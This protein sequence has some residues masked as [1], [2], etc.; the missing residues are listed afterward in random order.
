ML[1]I[2]G[3]VISVSGVSL[4]PLRF[5][6]LVRRHPRSIDQT[7]SLERQGRR[8][9]GG[10]VDEELIVFVR[11]VSEWGGYPKT[12]QR[13]FECND[14]SEVR[15]RFEN[16]I[17]A[18]TVDDPHIT[19]ALR[20]LRRIRGLGISFSSKHLRLLRPDVCP[21][22][23]SILSER[24]GYPLNVSGY[25]RFSDACRSVGKLLKER[26]IDNP[27]SRRDHEWYAADVEMA[28][29]VFVR[30]AFSTSRGA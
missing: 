20:E 13:V 15:R 7:R 11:R 6:E 18:L 28:V 24:L 16:A 9:L 27:M 17:H 23:D 30:E 10:F 29:Y 14:L 12:S 5:T 3:E 2:T 21:V 22:L 4:A 1:R 25:K 26:G 8:L 19:F